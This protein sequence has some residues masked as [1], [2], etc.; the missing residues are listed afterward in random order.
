VVLGLFVVPY[1]Y[2][3]A[4]RLFGHT[5]LE[6]KSVIERVAG[7]EES[8]HIFKAHPIIGSGLGNF[9]LALHSLD[10]KE[11]VWFYQPV[12]NI[13]SLLLS[14][15][16][17][18][19]ILVFAWLIFSIF[20]QAWFIKENRALTLGLIVTLAI[21]ACFDHWLISLHAGIFIGATSLGLMLKRD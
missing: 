17:I 10:S 14:E 6:T 11:L 3:F 18:F 15:I 1:Y 19:G 16:G 8:W 4:P 12:H 2:V 9:G 13:F 7:L 21:L 20:K 5:R